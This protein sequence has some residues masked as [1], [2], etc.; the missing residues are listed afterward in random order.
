[1]KRGNAIRET[2]TLKLVKRTEFELFPN[3]KAYLKAIPRP[4]KTT[5]QIKTA[6]GL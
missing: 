4:V 1:M 2:V 3:S 6:E 5:H